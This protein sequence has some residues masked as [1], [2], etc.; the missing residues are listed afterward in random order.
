MMVYH[1]H[2]FNYYVR[3]LGFMRAKVVATICSRVG[4]WREDRAMLARDQMVELRGNRD[5][6]VWDVHYSG[7]LEQG[8]R[9]LGARSLRPS[10]H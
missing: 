6:G 3:I 1:R 10:L 4:R 5:R 9:Y 7:F 2:S 8:W